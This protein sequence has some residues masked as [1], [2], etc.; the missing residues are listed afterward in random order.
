MSVKISATRG[1][2]EWNPTLRTVDFPESPEP[3]N[4]TCTVVDHRI[5]VKTQSS[6]MQRTFV[7][8]AS[9]A[10]VCSEATQEVSTPSVS[11]Q[12]TRRG[13][14]DRLLLNKAL[15]SLRSFSASLCRA[16]SASV[17]TRVYPVVDKH[18]PMFQ[19][20]RKRGPVDFASVVIVRNVSNKSNVRIRGP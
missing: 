7:C 3:S 17:T 9:L 11:R 16:T 13:E 20:V 2:P 8:E 19:E 6:I 18:P 14:P 5:H 4:S 12:S 1:V 10:F 15:T